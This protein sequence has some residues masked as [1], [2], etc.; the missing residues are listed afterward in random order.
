MLAKY[1]LLLVPHISEKY[2]PYW[3]IHNYRNIHKIKSR[4][5]KTIFR[6]IVMVIIVSKQNE[7]LE[8]SSLYCIYYNGKVIMCAIN[9]CPLYSC[10]VIKN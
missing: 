7:F 8:I 1:L 4:T 9:S 5:Q 10:Y 3:P 2:I 6:L